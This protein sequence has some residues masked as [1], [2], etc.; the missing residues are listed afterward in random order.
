[1]TSFM[2]N[3]ISVKESFHD[4]FKKTLNITPVNITSFT[5]YG[6]YQCRLSALFHPTMVVLLYKINHIH[7]SKSL[8]SIN[9]KIAPLSELYMY[10]FPICNGMI[11][12]HLYRIFHTLQQLDK[13]L[14]F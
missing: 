11:F 6:I 4:I 13:I 9:L 5:V 2:L 7:K 12:G 14:Q 1:M 3:L 10:T 8:L